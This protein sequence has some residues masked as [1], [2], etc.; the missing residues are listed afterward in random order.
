LEVRTV[1]VD[2]VI[3]MIII[4]RGIVPLLQL[5]ERILMMMI[6][7]MRMMIKVTLFLLRHALG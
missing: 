6:M 7:M 1:L 4:L 5:L 3:M 2:K